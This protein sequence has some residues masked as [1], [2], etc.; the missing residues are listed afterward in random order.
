MCFR[1]RPMP[2]LHFEKGIWNFTSSVDC[3]CCIVPQ[4]R[5]ETNKEPL[6]QP[7]S[8]KCRC[9]RKNNPS[10]VQ[11]GSRRNDIH[12]TRSQHLSFCDFRLLAFCTQT[13]S[14]FQA[15]TQARSSLQAVRRWHQIMMANCTGK[16]TCLSLGRGD[17]RAVLT[18][19]QL[20]AFSHRLQESLLWALFQACIFEPTMQRY[21]SASWPVVAA[22][23][24]A[25]KYLH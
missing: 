15:Y 20:H 24:Q 11:F 4:P 19:P 9:E 6:P 16:R 21:G 5:K 12:V 1:C 14:Q 17:Q 7:T 18:P 10:K 25:P 22:T 13:Q 2:D 23:S 3:A 8:Y